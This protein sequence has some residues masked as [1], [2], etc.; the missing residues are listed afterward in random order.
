MAELGVRPANSLGD[1]GRTSDLSDIQEEEEEEEEPEL[2][3]RA[4]SLQKQA[5]GTSIRENG[6][7]VTG[8]GGAGRP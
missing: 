7:K 8:C 5:A 2:G 1:H 4:C 6:P 3:P